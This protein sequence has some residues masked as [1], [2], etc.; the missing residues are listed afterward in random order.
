M[1][2]LKLGNMPGKRG[3]YRM[4]VRPGQDDTLE[5]WLWKVWLKG[6]IGIFVDEV[7]LVPQ[8]HA[9][10]AVLRQGRSKRIPVISCT[11]RPVDCDREVFS[12]AQY[13]MLYGIEDL[14]RDYPVIKG[15]FGGN[16]VRPALANL[17]RH[18]SL[19]YDAKQRAL[20]TLKPVPPPA[21]VA[22]K[23]RRIVPYGWQFGA[24][25]DR[26]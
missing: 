1:Q 13:R 2:W 20:S 14:H 24:L 17:P 23:L 10:K 22:Q 5:D 19:W 16:D 21:E 7:S 15:L 9:F 25:A 11:Q 18:W 6:N 4:P 8:R 3:L 26:S 12:E